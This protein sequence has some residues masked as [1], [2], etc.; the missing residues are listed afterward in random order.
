MIGSSSLMAIRKQGSTSSS[1][2]EQMLVCSDLHVKEDVAPVY[3]TEYLKV[4]DQA[5]NMFHLFFSCFSP[6]SCIDLI[7]FIVRNY[8]MKEI[9]ALSLFCSF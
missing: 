5:N 2:K 6:K 3:S 8:F 4:S 7:V 9:M 1:T